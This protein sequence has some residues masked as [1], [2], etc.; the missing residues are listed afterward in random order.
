MYKCL[1]YICCKVSSEF[2]KDVLSWLKDN[3]II[4]ESLNKI[5]LFLG[6]FEK[7]GRFLYN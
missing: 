3:N 2:W 5:G 4:I 1:V 7:N 6:N